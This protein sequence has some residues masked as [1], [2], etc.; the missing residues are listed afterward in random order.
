MDGSARNETSTRRGMLRALAR[1]AARHARDGVEIV[2]PSL[3]DTSAVAMPPLSPAV[4]E[5]R[6]ARSPERVASVQELLA[7][8]HAEGLTRRDAELRGLARRSL[9]M[10]PIEAARAPAWILTAENWDAGS[11]EVLLATINLAAIS[12]EERLPAGQGWLTLFV[13]SGT[14]TTDPEPRRAHGVVLDAPPALSSPA[15]PVGLHPELVI[16]RRWHEAVQALDLDDREAEAYDR[17]RARLQTVQGV[18]TDDHGGIEIAYHR[19]LGYPNE[20]SGGMPL[21]CVRAWR[22]C[23]LPDPPADES[24]LLSNAWRLLA[25]VSIGE[26]RR[27][28]VW[29]HAGDLV[30]AEFGR[31]FAFVR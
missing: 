11:G 6:P 24:G 31:L 15:E 16:P 2:G 26:R 20:T 23:S 25:Q 28:Y 4:P 30:G 21:D 17:L 7:I 1:T 5:R 19:L 29:I 13:E 14:Q 18:E 12:T 8:A 10:T 22:D 27:A 3:E 9:R